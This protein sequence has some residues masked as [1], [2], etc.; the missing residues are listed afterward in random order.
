MSEFQYS[1]L[2]FP[3]QLS[4]PRSASV[5]LHLIPLLL[6]FQV[7]SIF[8]Q[9]EVNH[10][11]SLGI[12]TPLRSPARITLTAQLIGNSSTTFDKAWPFVNPP[13]IDWV[14]HNFKFLIHWPGCNK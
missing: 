2:K 8:D 10:L 7:R 13:L 4:F 3:P 9:S 1:I 12:E 11:R 14:V 5:S 6:V